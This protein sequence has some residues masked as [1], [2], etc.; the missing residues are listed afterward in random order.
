M[1][2]GDWMVLLKRRLVAIA[3]MLLLG[4]CSCA[5]LDRVP[6]DEVV[7][8]VW[9][10]APERA[11]IEYVGEYQIFENTTS[12]SG[13]WGRIS[14]FFFGPE[15]AFM[16]R[17]Y[18]VSTDQQGRLFVA[19]A[20]GA[21]VHLFD[22]TN[23][24]YSVI[25]GTEDVPLKSPISLLFFEGKL[26][27]TDSARG[28]I[29]QYDLRE[30]SIKHWSLMQFERP[31]GLSFDPVS[32]WFYVSDSQAHQI[33]VLD[34]SGIELFRF[35][36][37][38]TGPG[39]F[40]FP[41]DS[42]VDSERRLYVTD[43]LN[44]RIQIFSHDGSYRGEFGQPGDTPGSFAKPKGVAVDRHGRVF[45]CDALF[46]A[47]Q[48]FDVSGQL[49]LTFGDSG[50][51]AGQFWMPSGI[52]IDRDNTIYVSDTYNRRIQIFRELE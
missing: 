15:S 19:D 30:G 44:A 48:I 42:W 10:P 1:T 29:L 32:G 22:M 12:R 24:R 34:R 50:R 9:P 41:T 49:L 28:R 51:E 43:S 6:Q 11:R 33:V 3:T 21:K 23:E 27:I 38:G 8:P 17:P 13:F 7:A 45:V 5:T 40:N 16:V 14:D 20:G 25:R 18:G 36:E 2:L 31:T 52:F 26:Y 47:V 4:L 37:R 35:G 46:D 39:Q